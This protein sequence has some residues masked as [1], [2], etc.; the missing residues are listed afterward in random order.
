MEAVIIALYKQEE[1]LRAA[2]GSDEVLNQTIATR[3]LYEELLAQ[4][5]HQEANRIFA[6]ERKHAE[7]TKKISKREARRYYKDVKR[8]FLANF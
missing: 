1:I 5:K 3:L 7:E 4:E 6:E 2:G 8:K